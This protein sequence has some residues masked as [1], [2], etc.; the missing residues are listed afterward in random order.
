[1]ESPSSNIKI[2][3][4]NRNAETTNAKIT[5]AKNSGTIGDNHCIHLLT[6]PVVDH[7]GHLPPVLG[8][9]VHPPGSP[10]Q[11]GEVGAGPAHS[12]SVDDGGHLKEVVHQQSDKYNV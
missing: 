7:A 10:V 2:Q 9:E 8:A 11:V 3:F 5:Q 1:M 12:R 4:S 6:V